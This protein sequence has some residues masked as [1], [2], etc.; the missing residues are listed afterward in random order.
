MKRITPFLSMRAEYDAIL[1][2]SRDARLFRDAARKAAR[3]AIAAAIKEFERRMFLCD[4]YSWDIAG[5]R[6]RKVGDE[7]K[8]ASGA[9]DK[10]VKEARDHYDRVR[11]YAATATS[12]ARKA[13]YALDAASYNESD[14]PTA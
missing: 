4:G 2:A 5:S 9:Y 3:S 12:K 1:I 6:P 14:H 8:A 10:A 7:I 13:R 11:K